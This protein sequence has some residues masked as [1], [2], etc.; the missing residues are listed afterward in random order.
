M[1]LHI[2]KLK[3]DVSLVLRHRSSDVKIDC[4]TASSIETRR[5]D[6]G[7]AFTIG[8]LIIDAGNASSTFNS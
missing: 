8:G 2:G 6:G 5:F 4:S 7:S 1:L 3:T